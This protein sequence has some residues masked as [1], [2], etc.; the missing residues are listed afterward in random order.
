MPQGNTCRNHTSTL[1]PADKYFVVYFCLV[2][3]KQI[4]PFPLRVGGIIP[5]GN[6]KDHAENL[7]EGNCFSWPQAE[8]DDDKEVRDRRLKEAGCPT[9][10]ALYATGWGF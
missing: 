6:S 8:R 4:P 5:E 3:V 9:L 7:I 2:W 1:F 10:V